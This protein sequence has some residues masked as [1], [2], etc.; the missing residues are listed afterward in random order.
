MLDLDM[1]KIRNIMIYLEDNIQHKKT[2]QSSD[3]PLIKD[4]SDEAFQ[5][6]SE[7]IQLLV[8]SNFIL[9]SKLNIYEYRIFII[10]IITPEGYS[11]LDA[12]RCNTIWNYIKSM[13]NEAEGITLATAVKT[14]QKRILSNIR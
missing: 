2:I 5:D 10:S 14:A 4:S 13:L 7:H 6:F 1:G 8:D 12:A 3:I 9:A 11:F